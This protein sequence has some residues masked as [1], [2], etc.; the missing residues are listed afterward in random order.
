MDGGGDMRLL[1]KILY[2]G[3]D[4]HLDKKQMFIRILVLLTVLSVFFSFVTKIT[5]I[6]D[7]DGENL[8]IA[9]VGPMSGDSQVIGRSLRQGA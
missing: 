6:S 2:L 3:T 9:V 4:G 5:F 1:T 7:D 8:R